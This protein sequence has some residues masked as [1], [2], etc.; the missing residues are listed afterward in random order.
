[1]S[2][3]KELEQASLKGLAKQ[4]ESTK[5]AKT[6]NNPEQ[7][8][9]YITHNT[10]AHNVTY[11][12]EVAQNLSKSEVKIPSLE[13]LTSTNSS[14]EKK[15][16]TLISEKNYIE[17]Y[18]YLTNKNNNFSKKDTSQ[19]KKE[20]NKILSLP[21]EIS[22]FYDSKNHKIL[23]VKSVIIN[24]IILSDNLSP[25]K[26]ESVI[27]LLLELKADPNSKHSYIYESTETPAENLLFYI[28]NYIYRLINSRTG[29]IPQKDIPFIKKL[30]DCT[31]LLIDHPN[32]II[33]NDHHFGRVILKRSLE[34]SMEILTAKD[35]RRDEE[36]PMILFAAVKAKLID[37]ILKKNSEIFLEQDE[38]GN[39]ALH[40]LSILS[41]TKN[42]RN[43]SKFNNFTIDILTKSII[44]I[45]EPHVKGINTPNHH[46]STP[47]HILANNN[48]HVFS[49][50]CE[51]A[52]DNKIWPD[53][54]K[55]DNQGQA[56]LQLLSLEQSVASGS[57]L[58]HCDDF[59]SLGAAINRYFQT[60]DL[61]TLKQNFLASLIVTT[62]CT[63]IKYWLLAGMEL[64]VYDP[65]IDT[66]KRNNDRYYLSTDKMQDFSKNLSEKYAL[67]AFQGKTFSQYLS[68]NQRS[69]ERLL[70][71]E[72]DK[73]RIQ[74]LL[75]LLLSE[76]RKES[77]DLENELLRKFS[78]LE[79]ELLTDDTGP[80]SPLIASQTNILKS[81]LLLQNLRSSEKS[82]LKTIV[83]HDVDL[84]KALALSISQGMKVK[85]ESTNS[86]FTLPYDTV[87][88][89]LLPLL[90][91]ED[92][93]NI[94]L[95]LK[96]FGQIMQCF[97]ANINDKKTYISPSKE[98]INHTLFCL[99]DAEVAAK[100]Q[101]V[102][103]E[104][105]ANPFA[106]KSGKERWQNY[107]NEQRAQKAKDEILAIK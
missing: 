71:E 44:G 43:N 29:V 48:K 89:H 66:Y 72:V 2:K 81:E 84:N 103:L 40:H 17:A 77:L 60:D 26:K 96:D 25:A 105:L 38:H 45:I 85:D 36:N 12:P 87:Y 1:M 64:I 79:N 58:N 31:N 32:C 62:F 104:P 19:Y 82:Q 107:I 47:L 90:T 42:F 68:S 102:P 70:S 75:F 97:M 14:T 106:N 99:V 57:V 41:D 91:F 98:G 61:S 28:H 101:Q 3:R 78:D 33:R 11:A 21:L 46:G 13:N 88:N 5:K 95:V 37:N 93:K 30:L 6:E 51:K 80:I 55:L 16:S 76:S 63:R 54:I 9:Q 7:Y 39:T 94:A 23:S 52:I 59:L 35:T 18:Q 56:V 73:A 27:K 24:D 34:I 100:K 10:A 20:L 49:K 67:N 4:E 83:E 65:K 74:P 92:F 86:V 53:L 8:G 50:L 69:I 22:E 15:Q